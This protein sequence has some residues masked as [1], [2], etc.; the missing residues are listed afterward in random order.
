MKP[1][2]LVVSN[3]PHEQVDLDAAP[4]IIAFEFTGTGL[5]ARLRSRDVVVPYDVDVVGQA[6]DPE[7]EGRPYPS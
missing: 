5:E 6:Q 3:P 2:T 7:A 4:A 1:P